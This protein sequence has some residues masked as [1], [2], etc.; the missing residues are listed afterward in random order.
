[1][2]RFR[3]F[4][5]DDPPALAAIWAAAIGPE[6]LPLPAAVFERSIY[7][8]PYF[9]PGGLIVAEWNGAPVGFVHAGFGPNDDETA[10][11][12]R[13]GVVCAVLVRPEHRRR[14]IGRQLMARAEDYLGCP[15]IQAGPARPLNP[16]YFGLYGGSDQP[17][18]LAS[19][20]SA[21]PFLEQCGFQ[22]LHS[23]LVL[24]RRFSGP[25]EP[26]D[27]RAADIRRKY[28][29]RFLP[30]SSI[31]SWWQDCVLGWI[32]PVEFRLEDK[33][34]GQPAA[35]IVVWEMDNFEGRWSESAVGILELF[36]RSDVRRQGLG[37]YIV[38]QLLRTIQEQRF[39]VVKVQFPI[40]NIAAAGLFH[41]LGF[42][43]VDT[44]H[45]YLKE[46]TTGGTSST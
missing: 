29:I 30:G 16:F 12:R 20:A 5:N 27:V 18:V 21:G 39:G 6:S 19:D 11:D 35:R 9:D 25:L 2:L 38:D 32:E 46:W 36:V 1:M 13:R 7:S 26:A 44:G 31:G 28:E 34:T 23:S 43:H 24:E 14:G 45:A 33:R 41:S 4:R 40:D 8:K 22:V 3:T 42:R 17:G 37:R 10:I 15:T